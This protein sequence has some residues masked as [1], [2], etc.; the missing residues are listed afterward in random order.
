M[1]LYATAGDARRTAHAQTEVAFALFQMGEFDAAETAGAQALAA[2]Q[3]C[4]D[5]DGM[6]KGQALLAMLAQNRPDIHA[7][8]DC[9]A[10][11]L[12]AYK[13]V[14]NEAGAAT[15]LSNVAELEFRDGHPEEAL[16]AVSE[17][18]EIDVRGKNSEAIAVDYSN[19]AAYR[20]AFDDLAGAR[21]WAREG[22]RVARGARIELCIASALQH[23]ALLSALTGDKVRVAQLLG[24][25]DGRFTELGIK[26][27]YTE[28]WGYDK[29]L[30]ILRETLT[31]DEIARLMAEGATWSE[32]RAAEEAP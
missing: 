14:G 31:E 32:D 20:L 18:L 19:G 2:L 13:A 9:F 23:L 7:A 4:G 27:E 29:L 11:A 15:V 1:Q 26:R 17:S 30:A 22:L 10:Q 3:A 16:R 5:A 28:Q 12:A 6:A 8:R 21:E 25:T 24:Y